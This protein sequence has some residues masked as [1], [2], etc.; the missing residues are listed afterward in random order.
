M[1]RTYEGYRGCLSSSFDVVQKFVNWLEKEVWTALASI[2]PQVSV[3]FQDVL[4]CSVHAGDDNE[5]FSAKL[6]SPPTLSSA[7]LNSVGLLFVNFSANNLLSHHA[8]RCIPKVQVFKISWME[9]ANGVVTE[10]LA[11]HW[12][13]T[14]P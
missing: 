6:L 8:C 2:A 4:P 3:D 1:W 7:L 10:V 11:M 9:L 5:F 13:I 14:A 12:F